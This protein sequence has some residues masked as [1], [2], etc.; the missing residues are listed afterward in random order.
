M[1]TRLVYPA[2]QPCLVAGYA[3]ERLAA[4]MAEALKARVHLL[5]WDGRAD[6]PSG[7]L[8]MHAP[9]DP[10]SLAGD[11]R[12]RQTILLNAAPGAVTACLELQPAGLV[13]Q[14]AMAVWRVEPDQAANTGI[15]LHTRLANA[16][17][18]DV[19]R[20]A[21]PNVM[22]QPPRSASLPDLLAALLRQAS[23]TPPTLQ[24]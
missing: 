10:G 14:T 2:G 4:D 18:L 9:D 17:H 5:A 15:W 20:T 22:V 1:D 6:L 7:P 23:L 12:L 11:G 19:L 8:L 13:T 24:S 16:L 3:Y 21:G